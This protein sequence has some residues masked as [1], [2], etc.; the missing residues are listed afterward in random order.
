MKNETRINVSG[1]GMTYSSLGWTQPSAALCSPV[2][3]CSRSHPYSSA[4]LAVALGK[5]GHHRVEPHRGETKQ[6]YKEKHCACD[7]H[8]RDRVSDEPGLKRHS[9]FVREVCVFARLVTLPL[10]ESSARVLWQI[11]RGHAS[12]VGESCFACSETKAAHIGTPP[13]RRRCID[14]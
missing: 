6:T 7:E 11:S 2:R 1:F 12:V 8:V 5:D 14:K 3:D 9:D 10:R 4:G 13:D